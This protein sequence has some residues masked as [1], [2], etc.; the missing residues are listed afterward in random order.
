MRE[1]EQQQ[2]PAIVMPELSLALGKQRSIVIFRV[3]TPSVP[4]YEGGL[5][6]PFILDEGSERLSD[7]FVQVVEATEELVFGIYLNSTLNP[8][9]SWYLGAS[10]SHWFSLCLISL[11]T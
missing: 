7:S 10:L 8:S 5:P 9:I 3:K 6:E 11:G 4:P 1:A 2:Q